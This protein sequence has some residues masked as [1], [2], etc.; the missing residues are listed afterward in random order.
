MNS[1]HL[2]MP[3]R[4]HNIESIPDNAVGIYGFWYRTTGKCIYVGKAKKQPIKK[5]LKQHWRKSHNLELR[6]WIDEFG[7][8]LDVCYISVE[9]KKRIDRME[10]RLIRA[11]DPEA[12]IQ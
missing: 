12:N 10:K 7:E 3:F 5:R 2:T 6:L 11:W 1:K 8:F 9:C 4:R